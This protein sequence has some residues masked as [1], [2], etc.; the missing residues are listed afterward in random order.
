[1][2]RRDLH[3]SF[4]KFKWSIINL[5]GQLW[6][7]AFADDV[8]EK[9]KRIRTPR[10]LEGWHENY[11]TRLFPSFEIF[12]EHLRQAV[13]KNM[14]TFV[15]A[16][17]AAPAAETSV[18]SAESSEAHAGSSKEHA[19]GGGP[20]GASTVHA[21]TEPRPARGLPQ[22]RQHVAFGLDPARPP[23]YDVDNDPIV[24]T[25]LGDAVE[26][27]GRKKFESADEADPVVSTSLGFLP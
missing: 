3:G 11:Y 18:S 2:L 20:T 16:D 6:T 7:F 17:V 8:L 9:P 21:P 15:P 5:E 13:L 25:W 19:G 12:Q 4:D 10:K 23:N 24:A 14:E 27:T 26:W 22:S 1:M